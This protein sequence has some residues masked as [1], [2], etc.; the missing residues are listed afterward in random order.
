MMLKHL[1][2]ILVPP[3]RRSARFFATRGTIRSPE[4]LAMRNC[5]LQNRR[6]NDG[7]LPH[8]G[9][10]RV[11]TIAAL[12]V[13]LCEIVRRLSQEAEAGPHATR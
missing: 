6:K 4:F 7:R 2:K 3:A 5:S 9:Q 8:G 10:Q 11:E 1:R 13:H 12:A